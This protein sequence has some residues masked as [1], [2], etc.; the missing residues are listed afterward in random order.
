MSTTMIL[1]SAPHAHDRSTITRVMGH[2]CLALTPVT[3]FGLYLFGWPALLLLLV[4][5]ASAL[6]TELVCLKIAGKPWYRVLDGSAL[7]TGWLLALSLPPWAPWWIGA[8]GAAFG[9]ALGKHIYGGVGQ[10][11]FNPAMLARAALLIAFPVQ[12]TSWA[13]PHFLNIGSGAASAPDFAQAWQIT[14]GHVQLADGVTGA[15]ALGHMKTAFTQHREAA[16]VISNDFSLRQALLGNTGGSLGET[17]ELLVLAGGVWL[18]ALRI[19]SW[20]IPLS[21]LLSVIALAGIASVLAPE[22]N[23]GALFHISSGGVLLGA[24]FIATDPVTS[25]TTSRGRL[26]FGTG[27]GAVTFFIRSYGSFPEAVAFAVLFMNALTPLIDRYVR[28]RA[29]GR[30]RTGKPLKVAALTDRLKQEDKV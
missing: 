15:T 8:G 30:T 21:M 4:T 24:I 12:M 26:M 19:I 16:E 29:Y 22:H 9:I 13:L 3:C 28:P 1:A 18:L 14:F 10:N 23:A 11:L 2:V 17:S 27:C 7:L 25:P 5:C 6:V 20:E